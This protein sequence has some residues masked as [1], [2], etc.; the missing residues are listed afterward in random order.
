M[1]RSRSRTKPPP[2][3]RRPI[4]PRSQ[5][6]E[7]E[8]SFARRHR[9]ILQSLSPLRDRYERWAEGVDAPALD[10]LAVGLTVCSPLLGL[11]PGSLT[12]W[13]LDEVQELRY[14][15]KALESLGSG[16][17][18]ALVRATLWLFARFL[19]DSGLWTG[20]R[21]ALAELLTVFASVEEP[22]ACTCGC[23]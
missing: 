15:L 7:A 22:D 4:D 13:D 10:R 18:D 19:Q 12:H 1:P 23:S 11:R 9:A 21:D 16:R 6:T 8:R 3:S 2:R 17:V 20:S 14:A 5:R